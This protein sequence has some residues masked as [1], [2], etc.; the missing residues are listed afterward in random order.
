MLVGIVLNINVHLVPRAV[1]E[2]GFMLCMDHK[3]QPDIFLP[4]LSYS[5]YAPFRPTP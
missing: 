4:S 1:M 5:I 3:L 2:M